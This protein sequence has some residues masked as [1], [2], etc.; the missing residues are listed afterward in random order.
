MR[1]GVVDDL[2]E[3]HAAESLDQRADGLAMDDVRI[4]SAADIL[5]GDVVENLDL[6]RARIDRDVAGVSA[7]AIGADRG[8]EGAVRL[9]AGELG[10]AARTS[11]RRSPRRPRS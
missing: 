4:D 7:I 10:E 1:I 11:A 9:E 6:T 5:D 8:R 3:K 2:V